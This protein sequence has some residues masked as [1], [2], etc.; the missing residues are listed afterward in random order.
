[1]LRCWDKIKALSHD[2][3]E[4]TQRIADLEAELWSPGGRRRLSPDSGWL[5]RNRSAQHKL[6]ALRSET[7]KRFDEELFAFEAKVLQA[8]KMIDGWLDA[9]ILPISKWAVDLV[10]EARE[11]RKR[12]EDL[13]S[14]RGEGPSAPSH[15]EVPQAPSHAQDPQNADQT[16][17]AFIAKLWRR[18]SKHG[19]PGGKDP[20][21]Q[22]ALDLVARFNN[23][24]DVAG[25][26]FMELAYFRHPAETDAEGRTPLMHALSMC[27]FF[28]GTPLVAQGLISQMEPEALDLQ[29]HGGP[30][31]LGHCALHFVAG[32]SSYDPVSNEAIVRQL[33][34]RRASME[35]RT[36]TGLTPL[37]MA[38]GQGQVNVAKALVDAGADVEA[39]SWD[40]P[41]K[42]KT[43]RN[44]LD[45]GHG[46]SKQM[47]DWVDSL[48]LPP[49]MQP[50]WNKAVRAPKPG[51]GDSKEKRK[52]ERYFKL[53]TQPSGAEPRGRGQAKAKADPKSSSRAWAQ[54]Q[55]RAAHDFGDSDPRMRHAGPVG[56]LVTAR[57]REE[58]GDAA[59]SHAAPSYA[60]PAAQPAPW[61]RGDAQPAGRAQAPRG[62]KS[63][64]KPSQPPRKRVREHNRPEQ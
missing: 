40:V 46:S 4:H 2:D 25:R 59:P 41:E 8:Q 16:Y 34:R 7:R 50:L 10:E 35:L 58:H 23:D 31:Q 26:F 21:P 5:Q 15:D 53:G 22:A 63:H 28:P 18:P 60:E 52:E 37:L 33:I 24:P 32:P 64:A 47:G 38:V 56:A 1:M 12:S 54:L 61:P 55:R 44:I 9:D 3:R 27:Q 39:V 36:E 19:Y 51:G 30:V 14:A 49:D 17:R 20:A 48:D 57:V 62:A 6:N 13:A 43:E 45:F 11:V 42:G 29:V